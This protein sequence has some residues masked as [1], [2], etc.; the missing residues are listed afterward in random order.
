MVRAVL[1]P[2]RGYEC[3]IWSQS[4]QKWM[5]GTISGIYQG[6]QTPDLDLWGNLKSNSDD[7][8]QL[9]QSNRFFQ[10]PIGSVKVDFQVAGRQA[11]KVVAPENFRMLLRNIHKPDVIA[12]VSDDGCSMTHI[13]T[14]TTA[15]QAS[16]ASQVPVTGSFLGPTVGNL[17]GEAWMRG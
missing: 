3:E 4:Q 13:R 8:D 7:S 10:Y 15:S 16:Q 14:M 11:S 1:Y 12:E 6:N 17:A 5:N 9:D 2:K